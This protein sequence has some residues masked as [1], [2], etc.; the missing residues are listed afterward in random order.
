MIRF[1]MDVVDLAIRFMKSV[2]WTSER[3]S[4]RLGSLLFLNFVLQ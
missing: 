1:P 4:E 3:V 2:V